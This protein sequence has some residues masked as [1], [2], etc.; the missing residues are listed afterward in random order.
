[1][2]KKLSGSKHSH[3]NSNPGNIEMYIHLISNIVVSCAL[4]FLV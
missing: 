3:N 2:K 4:P 1:M